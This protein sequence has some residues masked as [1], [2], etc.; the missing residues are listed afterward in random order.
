MKR[1]LFII[2]PLSLFLLQLSAKAAVQDNCK[3]LKIYEKCPYEDTDKCGKWALEQKNKLC[4]DSEALNDYILKHLVSW[5]EKLK[6]LSFNFK[7][8]MK[9]ISADFVQES[10]GKLYYK[11]TKKQHLRLEQTKPERQIIWTDKKNIHIYQPRENE[12][13]SQAICMQWDAWSA[14]QGSSYL[15]IVDFGNYA[16]TFKTNRVSRIDISSNEVIVTLKPKSKYENYKLILYLRAQ[17]L[18]PVKINL[19]LEDIDSTVVLNKDTIKINKKLSENIFN[20]NI[21]KKVTTLNL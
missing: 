1:S 13:E 4:S 6:T 10:E 2:F 18:F 5:D 7:Q 14:Q 11:K 20:V 15:G 19:M 21:P 16:Q 12:K 17:D 8:T 9:F 3:H